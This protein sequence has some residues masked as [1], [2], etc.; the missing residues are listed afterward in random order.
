MEFNIEDINEIN[1]D[2]PILTV[3]GLNSIM[4]FVDGS[5]LV[6]STESVY[7]SGYAFWV[8]RNDGEKAS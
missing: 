2:K 7:W 6:C 3:A 5:L 4:D 1:T 8:L